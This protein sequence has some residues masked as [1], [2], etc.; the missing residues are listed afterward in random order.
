MYG[1][2]LGRESK[3]S[4]LSTTWNRGF[5]FKP[6]S[7]VTTQWSGDTGLSLGTQFKP[8]GHHSPKEPKQPITLR[9]LGTMDYK[10]PTVSEFS[11]NA[12]PSWEEITTEEARREAMDG[13]FDG[14][15]GEDG[16]QI[17]EC[18]DPPQRNW[19]YELNGAIHKHSHVRF[20]DLIAKHARFAVIRSEPCLK[21]SS[22][23]KP[24]THTPDCTQHRAYFTLKEHRSST[25]LYNKLGRD[26]SLWPAYLRGKRFTKGAMEVD[27]DNTRDAHSTENLTVY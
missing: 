1:P 5:G 15:H 25:W 27:R 4:Y 11:L 9:G 22:R 17:C 7:T 16:K 6:L 12:I 24:H 2:F 13:A 23:R 3:R 10:I 20:T 26:A 8:E 21:K 18:C 14:Q 19:I